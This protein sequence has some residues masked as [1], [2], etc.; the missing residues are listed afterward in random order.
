MWDSFTEK[1]KCRKTT[2]FTVETSI[3]FKVETTEPKW[4]E[5]FLFIFRISKKDVSK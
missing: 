5:E 3:K 2:E 1:E 4:R